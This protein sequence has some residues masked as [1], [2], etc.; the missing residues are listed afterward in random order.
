MLGFSG[1]AY[2]SQGSG[3]TGSSTTSTST[4]TNVYTSGS[5]SYTS[6]STFTFYPPTATI[7]TLNCTPGILPQNSPSVCTASVGPTSTS[8]TVYNPTGTIT[9]AVSGTGV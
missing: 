8:S 6:T 9:F 1:F 5:S 2:A 7:T 3:T 4:S